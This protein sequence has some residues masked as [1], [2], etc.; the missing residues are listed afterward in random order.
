[1]CFWGGW[2]RTK[3]GDS[4]AILR[5]TPCV[6][7]IKNIVSDTKLPRK[8]VLA[9]LKVNIKEPRRPLEPAVLRKGEEEGEEGTAAAAPEEEDRW[10]PSRKRIK[11]VNLETF[12][13]VY[14]IAP[15]PSVST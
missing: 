4:S 11:K 7:Q 10:G 6:F 1:M 13:K 14:R 3:K 2:H 9:W 15:Q 8:V 12:E 5:F